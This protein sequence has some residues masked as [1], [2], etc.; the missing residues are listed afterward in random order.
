MEP[1]SSFF[2]PRLI[3]HSRT[4]YLLTTGGVFPPNSPHFGSLFQ[5]TLPK[6]EQVLPRAL[7]LAT[8]IAENVSPLAS[9]LNRMMIWRGAN[10]AEEAHLMDSA[11]LYHM[12]SAKYVN[13]KAYQMTIL[14]I[15]NPQGPKRRCGCLLREE[16][17]EVQGYT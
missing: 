1:S 10:S 12:F 6:A 17:A 5:E 4:I 14:V 3:G 15:D 9:Y 2:L 11:I 7:E 16:E 13:P 8:E